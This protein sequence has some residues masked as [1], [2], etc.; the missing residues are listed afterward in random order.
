M[1][2]NR[3]SLRR[4]AR[5]RQRARPSRPPP[6]ANGRRWRLALEEKVEQAAPPPNYTSARAGRCPQPPNRAAARTRLASAEPLATQ[7]PSPP[8][9]GA[10]AFSSPPAYCSSAAPATAA[11]VAAAITSLPPPTPLP[12][13]TAATANNLPESTAEDAPYSESAPA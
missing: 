7:Q 1:N 9:V 4:V 5:W 12:T 6:N 8:L 13:S 2:N 11:L 3:P 10:P